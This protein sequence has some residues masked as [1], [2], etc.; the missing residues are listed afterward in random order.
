VTGV[1]RWGSSSA[2]CAS[3]SSSV[4]SCFSASIAAPFHL[5][6]LEIL[7]VFVINEVALVPVNIETTH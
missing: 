6:V 4:S 2:V 5:H 1:S 3:I 7:L